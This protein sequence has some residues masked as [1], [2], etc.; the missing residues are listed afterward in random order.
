MNTIKQW[1]ANHSISA[2]SLS[3]AWIFATTLFYTNQQFHDYVLQEYGLLPKGIKGFIAGAVVPVLIF[4]KTQ[5][6]T[7][8]TTTVAPG[9]TKTTAV[10]TAVK[11]TK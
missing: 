6:S 3:G 8:I 1:L 11:E 5:K 7:T 2:Q 10:T 4:W 9:D